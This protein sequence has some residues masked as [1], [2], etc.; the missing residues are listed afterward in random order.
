MSLF[1]KLNVLS[2][3]PITFKA[4][5]PLFVVVMPQEPRPPVLLVGLWG[6]KV[7]VSTKNNT[8]S[9]EKLEGRTLVKYTRK[10]FLAAKLQHD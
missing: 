9:I 10:C 5:F 1:D 4:L 3:M 8:T 7:T 2:Y 6:R